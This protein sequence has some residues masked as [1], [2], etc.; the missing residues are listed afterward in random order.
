MAPCVV[1]AEQL[2]DLIAF[3]WWLQAE[4]DNFKAVHFVRSIPAGASSFG[5][6]LYLS[7]RAQSERM[8]V[9][10]ARLRG[11]TWKMTHLI[12]SRCVCLICCFYGVGILSVICSTSTDD[13]RIQF[14][15]TESHEMS[16]FGLI[17]SLGRLPDFDWNLRLNPS[18]DRILFKTWS[19]E[20]W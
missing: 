10:S 5:C 8:S 9:P 17:G 16:N 14:F 6:S 15:N 2:L 18:S 7:C 19:L 13:T 3:N 4:F 12:I 1:G 11:S 20:H